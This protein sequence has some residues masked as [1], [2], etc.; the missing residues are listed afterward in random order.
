MESSWFTLILNDIQMT[1]T[2]C[3]GFWSIWTIKHHTVAAPPCCDCWTAICWLKR[4]FKYNWIIVMLKKPLQHNL[5]ILISP[6]LQL[7][8]AV[9]WTLHH[10]Y[11]GMAAVSNNGEL[12]QSTLRGRDKTQSLPRIVPL[13]S[14]T[15]LKLFSENTFFKLQGTITCCTILII[16]CR[17]NFLTFRG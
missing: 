5:S 17:Y 1:S 8:A 16:C 14:D 7:K 3:T 13:K 4:A 15:W 11:R 12:W 2:F 9:T 6:V 10:S